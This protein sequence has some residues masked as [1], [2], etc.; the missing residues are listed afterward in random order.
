MSSFT[1]NSNSNSTYSSPYSHTPI[2]GSASA[3]VKELLDNVVHTPTRNPEQ[4]LF[5]S[6]IMESMVLTSVSIGS[7]EEESVRQQGKVVLKLVVNEDMLNLANTVHGGCIAYIVDFCS[8]LALL[9]LGATHGDR[10]LSVSQAL[11][12]VF[13]SPAALGETLRIVNMSVSAGG[14]ATTART[15]IWNDTHHRLVASGVHIK[16]QPSSAKIKL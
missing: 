16:M 7:M 6:T 5:A 11:N 4:K 13:H 12:V 15:E 3:D 8:S 1:S 2:G 14:R 9:A 10:I